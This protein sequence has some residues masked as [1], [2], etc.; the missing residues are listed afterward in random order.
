VA[1]TTDRFDQIAPAYRKLGLDP[2]RMPCIRVESADASVLVHARQAALN[3]D[4]LLVSSGRTIELLWPDGSMPVT[5]V[6]AVGSNTAA[7][8]A[9]R[10]GRVVLS[11]HSGLADLV[12]ELGDRL[13]SAWVVF[14]RAAGSDPE[15]L[16]MIRREARLLLDFEIYRTIPVA[17]DFTPVRS[18]AFASPSAVRGWL[19]ARDL[20]GLVVGVIGAS[21]F[22]EVAQH[23]A[24]EVVAS[25]PS[26]ASLAHAMASYME[27]TV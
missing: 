26:H 6:A 7:A 12:K 20:V 14:P 23:R 19:L 25:Q 22:Q 10:G 3:A 13:T 5:P 27:V 8:V 1:I 9:A 11:G 17:P 4:L 24:P 16:E 15:T 18:V 2:V 21:T